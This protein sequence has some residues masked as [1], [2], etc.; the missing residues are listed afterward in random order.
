MRCM[1]TTSSQRP[2]LRPTYAFAADLLEAALAVQRDR[3]VVAADD[4][5]HHGMESVVGPERQD[6]TKQGLA[7]TVAP[8]FAVHVNGI[9]D[10]R[11]VGRTRPER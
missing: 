9:F 7:H 6:V 2:N 10:R 4:T 8:W 1:S 11:H 5:C 3:R